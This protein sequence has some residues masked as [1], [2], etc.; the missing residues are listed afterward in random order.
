MSSG[1]YE[2]AVGPIAS[3]I[4]AFSVGSKR[5]HSSW[6]LNNT[7]DNNTSNIPQQQESKM[8]FDADAKNKNNGPITIPPDYTGLT[9]FKIHAAF[10]PAFQAEQGVSG[11]R[12]LT[13]KEL[14]INFCSPKAFGQCYFFN[15]KVKDANFPNTEAVDRITIE[16]LGAL[17]TYGFKRQDNFNEGNSTLKSSLT[18]KIPVNSQTFATIMRFE[19]VVKKAFDA[20]APTWQKPNSTYEHVSCLRYENGNEY[21]ALKCSIERSKKDNEKI[22]SQIS[23][24]G[25]AGQDVEFKGGFEGVTPMSKVRVLLSWTGC[26]IINSSRKVYHNI[27]LLSCQVVSLRPQKRMFDSKFSPTTEAP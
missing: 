9:M 25:E 11:C 3:S 17:E 18:L 19:D 20:F 8:K 14:N 27:K 23:A 6:S 21:A 2:N 15:A 24:L 5:T 1:V 7:N 13:A 10:I 26:K 12:M 4:S 16:S 22:L